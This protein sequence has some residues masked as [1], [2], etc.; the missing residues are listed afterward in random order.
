MTADRIACAMGELRVTTASVE[1]APAIREL[2]NDLARWMVQR[3]IA[4][5]SPDEMSLEWIETCISWE[6]VHVVTLDEQLVGSVTV[7][8]SDPFIWGE[9][10]TDAGYIH[11]LI[12]DPQCRGHGIGRSILV[13][14]EASIRD[15][16]RPLARLDCVRTNRRLR[17]YYEAAGYRFV[18]HKG[19]PDFEWA[20]ETTLYE[21]SL[22]PDA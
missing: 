21:K 3:G 5:W 1:H 6:A 4:Q 16:G 20:G 19:F 22:V 18:A 2:R 10:P 8:W 11:M 14:A 13:W 7:V 17:D 9:R 15:A 12:V